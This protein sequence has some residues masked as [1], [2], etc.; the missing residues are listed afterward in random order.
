[1]LNKCFESE[2]T[3]NH[4][5][6]PT[7]YLMPFQ[8]SCQCLTQ[9]KQTIKK[10]SESPSILQQQPSPKAQA[11]TATKPQRQSKGR[12]K[13]P[14]LSDGL[15]YLFT[16]RAAYCFTAAFAFFPAPPLTVA[17]SRKRFSIPSPIPF[18][19]FNSSTLL[20]LPFCWR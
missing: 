3:L 5:F 1:M 14:P 13:A 15:L 8:Y 11:T 2:G 6:A 17:S 16:P 20:N 18:T 4:D 19:F 10:P 9:Y 7:N 12:L